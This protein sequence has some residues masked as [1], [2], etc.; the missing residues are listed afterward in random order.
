MEKNNIGKTIK[1]LRKFHGEKQI[2]LANELG[3]T[4]SSICDYEHGRREPDAETLEKIALH[5]G[6]T[7]DDIIRNKLYESAGIDSSKIVDKNQIWNVYFR[8]LPLIETEKAYRNKAYSDGMK[9][10]K[11]II[12]SLSDGEVVEIGCLFDVFELFESAIDDDVSEA[13]ANTIW[14]IFFLWSQQYDSADNA[15]RLQNRLNNGNVDWK[16]LFDEKRKIKKSTIAKRTSFIQDFDETLNVFIGYLK[17]TEDW[18]ELGDYYL[19]LR[20]VLGLVDTDCSDEMNQEVGMQMMLAFTQ[21]GNEYALDF[22]KANN[23]IE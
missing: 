10:L 5:Y 19:A 23:E 1:Y 22:L 4:K 8:T 15:K 3:V 17:C 14:L 2:E 21:L 6:I 16:E 20:Y 11:E 12:N 7:L 13:V 18:A 9:K